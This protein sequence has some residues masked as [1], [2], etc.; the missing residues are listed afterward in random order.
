[1]PRRARADAG[2]V[3]FSRL[4]VAV[5]ALAALAAFQVTPVL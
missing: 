5:L 2:H 4:S 3:S 1:M